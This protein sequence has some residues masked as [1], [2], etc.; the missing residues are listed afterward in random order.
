MNEREGRLWRDELLQPCL[1][2]SKYPRSQA[3]TSIMHQLTHIQPPNQFRQTVCTYMGID[4]GADAPYESI[5]VPARNVGAFV[6]VLD[7]A[8]VP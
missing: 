3:L 8:G 5:E 6:E 1:H 2:P 4:R 7:G